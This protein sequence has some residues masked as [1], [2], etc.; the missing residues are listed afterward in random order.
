MNNP[1]IFY[2]A[3]FLMLLFA[4][5]TLSFRNIFYSLISAIVV[6]FFAGVFFYLLG[7]EYNAV[8]QIAIYG[9][10]VPVILGVAVMFTNLRNGVTEEKSKKSNLKYLLFLTCG[11]FV[12]SLIY[13]MMTSF[14][15]VPNGFNILEQSGS[16]NLNSITA[17]G[18]GIFV[19]YVWAFELL[20][21]ILTIIVVGFTMFKGGSKCVK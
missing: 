19:N 7:S 3:V 10:A 21:L 17:F 6:F 14:M 9:V 2:S 18:N 15:V 13:L 4:I 8:I 16:V 5:L 11:L 20:S 12:L 1:I